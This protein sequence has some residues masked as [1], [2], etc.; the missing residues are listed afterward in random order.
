VDDSSIFK[1]VSMQT[2]HE[3]FLSNFLLFHSG[4]SV[5]LFMMCILLNA[6]VMKHQP[7][8]TGVTLKMYIYVNYAVYM[9]DLW[10]KYQLAVPLVL[11]IMCSYSAY[12]TIVASTQ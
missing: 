9:M 8:S 11:M 2:F 10:L 3:L 12:I 7:F 5:S 1:K 4:Q 6:E